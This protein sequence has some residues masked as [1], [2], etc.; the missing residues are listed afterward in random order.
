MARHDHNRQLDDKPARP[1]G[2]QDRAARLKSGYTPVM[3]SDAEERF[4]KYL[5]DSDDRVLKD[6]V[7]TKLYRGRQEL[8][9]IGEARSRE[10]FESVKARMNALLAGRKRLAHY[11][12]DLPFH[13]DYID[14]DFG[15]ALAF[16]DNSYAFI[17]I[18]LPMIGEIQKTCRDLSR[19]ARIREILE[20]GEGIEGKLEVVLFWNLMNLVITHEYTH[21]IH[22]HVKR[23][24]GKAK[25]FNEFDSNQ[26]DTE[27]MFRQ[28]EE[29]DADG[30]GTYQVLANALDTG[31]R[32]D[33]VR[34]LRL[35]GLSAEEIDKMFLLFHV[36][37]ACA[38]FSINGL[39]DVRTENPRTKE[40]PIQACRLDFLMRHT[41]LWCEPNRPNLVDDI[42]QETFSKVMEAVSAE[43]WGIISHLLW[44]EQGKYLA[45]EDGK[46]YREELITLIDKLK[47]DLGDAQ[48]AAV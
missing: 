4:H 24:L 43:M 19:S 8:A 46:K 48:A 16:R 25:F 27:K 35:E 30:F 11:I 36:L 1:G 23:A 7:Y 33:N 42:T 31:L 28:A 45:T 34:F 20:V 38:Q 5:E 37:V 14:S 9:E 22:G 21:H 26:T 44:R 47:E 6:G 15:N 18:S 2:F 13:F 40:H 41:K 29:V 3:A 32:D 17:G 12:D 10:F 39:V